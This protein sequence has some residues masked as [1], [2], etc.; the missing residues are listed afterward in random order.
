MTL[1]PVIHGQVIKVVI[2]EADNGYVVEKYRK[3]RRYGK[4]IWILFEHLSIDRESLE[5]VKKGR[6]RG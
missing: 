4:D 6:G 2:T 1:Q 5:F 3:M